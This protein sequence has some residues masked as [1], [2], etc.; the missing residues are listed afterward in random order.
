MDEKNRTEPPRGV[1]TSVVGGSQTGAQ[2]GEAARKVQQTATEVAGQAQARASDLSREAQG[3]TADLA[4]EAQDRAGKVAGTAQDRAADVLQQA[5]EGVADVAASARDRLGEE[6][7]K[8]KDRAASTVEGVAGQVH[9][10]ADRLR[11][12]DQRWLSDFV[13]QGADEL[14][15]FAE[16]LR[17]ND[18]Q[19]LIAKARGF[20]HRQPALFA[21]ASVAAGFALARMAR[22]AVERGTGAAL[23]PPQHPPRNEPERQPRSESIPSQTGTGW[24]PKSRAEVVYPGSTSNG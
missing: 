16:V 20:A 19:G 4:R 7:G 9:D 24:Q 3:R 12:S 6:A 11:E 15:S 10:V 2:A 21:G 8:Q 5:Q 13:E 17:S 14:S 1:R 22:I 18:L 23:A